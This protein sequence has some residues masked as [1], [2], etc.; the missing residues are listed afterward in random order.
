MIKLHFFLFFLFLTLSD[1]YKFYFLMKKKRDM[2]LRK[3]LDTSI[4]EG[5]FAQVYSALVSIGNS[6]ITKFAVLLNA[7][8]LHFSII[9]AIAQLSQLFQI[10]GIII[11]KRLKSRKK[12]CV[13]YAFYGRAV[14]LFLFI[15]LLIIYSKISLLGMSPQILSIVIFLLILLISAA[16]QNI[17]G[18]LWTAWISDLVPKS[19]RGRFFS[20]R[21]QILSFYGLIFAYIFSIFVDC[22]ESSEGNWKYSIIE[23]TGLTRIFIPENQALGLYLVFFIGIVIGLLGLYFLNQQDEKEVKHKLTETDFSIKEPLKNKNFRQLALFNAWWMLAIGI[24]APFWGAF[25]MKK[26]HMSLFEI[27]MYGAISSLSMLVAFKWWGKFIDRFGNRTTMKICVFLGG[28]NP[29]IWVFFTK[30]SYWLIWPEAILSGFMWSGT[31]I[32]SMNFILAI[33]PKGK[34]Q[35]WSGVY[36]A[37]GGVMMMSTM[38]LSGTFFPNEM[39]LF[40]LKLEPEQVLFALTGVLRWTAEI[41]LHYVKEAGGVPFRRTL[42]EV[43]QLLFQ[44]IYR[45][46]SKF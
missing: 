3:A 30:E 32:V 2:R 28:I 26:L 45:L 34:E 13:W 23:F 7:S 5:I 35:I 10:I 20:K 15:P 43:R 4:F 19:I 25:M 16:L 22:F 21:M 44:R 9:S 17:S 37:I 27:Q 12:K 41:P 33:S 14:N 6:F 11:T 29:L 39:Y 46:R 31:N 40:G 24:G 1:I 36:S 38:L 8:P 42:I 18:N